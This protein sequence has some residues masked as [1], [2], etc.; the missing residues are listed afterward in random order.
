MMG[1]PEIDSRGVN[2]AC[3]QRVRQTEEWVY[4][5]PPVEEGPLL[6]ARPSGQVDR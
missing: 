2:G 1:Q 3:S 6:R 5:A 4:R